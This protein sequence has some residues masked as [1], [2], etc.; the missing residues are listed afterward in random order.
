MFPLMWKSPPPPPPPPPPESFFEAEGGAAAVAPTG[1]AQ[2]QQQAQQQAQQQQQ[3]QAQQNDVEEDLPAA[4]QEVIGR[5]ILDN[6]DAAAAAA[7]APVVDDDNEPAPENRPQQPNQA[8]GDI[9][10]EWGHSGICARR[11]TIRNNPKPEMKFWKSC[12]RPSLQT[13]TCLKAFSFWHISRQQLFPKQT[14]ISTVVMTNC[15]MESSC[16]GLVCGYS[17]QPWLVH[18]DMSIGQHTPSTPSG[19]RLFAWVFG[20]LVRVST[21]FWRHCHSL[22]ANPLLFLT[23]FGRSTR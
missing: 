7:A 10:G 14:K 6:D 3:Q 12:L 19:E 2:Q 20:C 17:C 13:L 11:S 15:S 23:N 1:E 5:G 4:I 16:S 18:N 22:I 9:F 8:V 21:Q